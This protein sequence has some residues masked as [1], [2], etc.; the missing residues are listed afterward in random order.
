[1]TVL[2]KVAAKTPPRTRAANSIPL[3]DLFPIAWLML[4]ACNG[5]DDTDTPGPTG[6]RH[7]EVC[8]DAAP[9]IESL[10]ITDNGPTEFGSG[11]NAHTWPAI[12]IEAQASDADGDL[13]WYTVQVWFDGLPDGDIDTTEEP[14][15]LTTSISEE[16]CSVPLATVGTIMAVNGEPPPAVE[17][18]FG[19]VVIDA[20]GHASEVEPY[21]FITPEA[22]DSD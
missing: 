9:L 20:E 19:V 21:T 10:T 17:L 4:G 3:R 2:K 5:A 7:D 15:E 6:D 22:L 16:D 8:G 11:D 14:F 12:R 18:E 13:D 1:M